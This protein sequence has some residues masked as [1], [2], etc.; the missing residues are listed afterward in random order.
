MD[1][2]KFLGVALDVDKSK[3]KSLGIKYKLKGM[4]KDLKRVGGKGLYDEYFTFTVDSKVYYT[5]SYLVVSADDISK[6][7]E[8]L[9]SKKLSLRNKQ[10]SLISMVFNNYNIVDLKHFGVNYIPISQFQQ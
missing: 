7:R 6:V 2:A 9:S 3:S 1:L 5:N 8:A 4:V 10:R